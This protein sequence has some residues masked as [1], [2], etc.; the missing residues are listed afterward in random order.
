MA[1]DPDIATK[2]AIAHIAV[3]AEIPTVLQLVTVYRWDGEELSKR[4]LMLFPI[5][6]WA[7][8]FAS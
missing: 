8:T 1:I 6:T 5:S 3:E 7:I 4:M 2:P